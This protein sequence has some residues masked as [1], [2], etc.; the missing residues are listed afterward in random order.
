[1]SKI[2]TDYINKTALTIPQQF[3]DVKTGE[4]QLVS[5]RIQEQI[6]YHANNSTL[7]H[8]VLSALNSYLHPKSMNGRAEEILLELSELKKMMQQTQT[9][10]KKFNLDANPIVTQ[11]GNIGLDLKEVEEILEGF[12]G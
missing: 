9:S 11:E 6:E 5:T 4:H 1:M 3:I 8:L 2:Y 10:D 12:G 7:I